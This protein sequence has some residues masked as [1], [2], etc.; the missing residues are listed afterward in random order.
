MNKKQKLVLFLG[1]IAIA[2]MI[3]FPPLRVVISQESPSGVAAHA[4]IRYGFLITGS[5]N[6]IYYI[7]LILQC[8]TA[9]S[10]TLGLNSLFS[11][12]DKSATERADK[13]ASINIELQKEIV[14]LKQEETG[15]R[16]Q[17][18]VLAIANEKLRTDMQNLNKTVD[19]WL[20]YRKYLEN[21]F[22]QLAVSSPALTR[23]PASGH[24]NT[25]R[26]P[27]E[28]DAQPPNI[29][30]DS[31]DS[32]QQSDNLKYDMIRDRMVTEIESLSDFIKNND[33]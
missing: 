28:N 19:S 15:V 11:R 1:F 3:M 2:L 14:K 17:A 16:R 7:R 4:E 31:S 12:I 18:E 5:L 26:P 9:L 23:P 33:L 27:H 30:Q 6:N 22:E 24:F 32:P 29:N 8:L 25:P 20:E 13:L 21:R 10:L